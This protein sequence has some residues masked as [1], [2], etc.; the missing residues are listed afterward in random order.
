MARF[1]FRL[2]G[3]LELRAAR[4]EA[5]KRELRLAQAAVI[6]AERERDAL[7]DKKRRLLGTETHDLVERQTLE[8]AVIHL[9][10]RV[11]H[12]RIAIEQLRQ[13]SE[14]AMERWRVAKMDL[15]VME[16]LR[17]KAFEA[18]R[19]EESRREQAELDE[20]AVLRR[21]AA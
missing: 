4:E 5:A 18:Y 15:E 2:Q 10:D 6:A 7:F 9:D 8:T 1:R 3:V 21:A 12:Q 13:E 19:L 16:R 20:F 11:R 17:E 14:R